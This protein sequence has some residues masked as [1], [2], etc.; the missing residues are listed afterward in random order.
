MF[1]CERFRC[2]LREGATL[3]RAALLLCFSSPSHSVLI[4][5]TV[6]LIEGL[7]LFLVFFELLKRKC[8]YDSFV[9]ES[10]AATTCFRN[11]F[12]AACRCTHYFAVKKID[13]QKA[14]GKLA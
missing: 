3:H 9:G 7:I 1:S 12:I 10:S 6:N 5:S 4:R 13:S 8:P 2:R 14:F 11:R